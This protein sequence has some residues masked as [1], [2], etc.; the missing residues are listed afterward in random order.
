LSGIVEKPRSVI[1]TARSK[2]L[3]AVEVEAV[4]VGVLFRDVVIVGSPFDFECLVFSYELDGSGFE[5]QDHF[6]I[7]SIAL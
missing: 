3:V 1:V 4:E 5:L 6:A 7:E 2:K